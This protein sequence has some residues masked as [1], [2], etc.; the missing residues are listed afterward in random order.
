MTDKNAK[1]ER[2]LARASRAGP[3]LKP[4]AKADGNTSRLIDQRIRNLGIGAGKHWR[5]FAAH[6]RG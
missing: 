2:A 5:G 6:S 4:Q 1:P 3:L